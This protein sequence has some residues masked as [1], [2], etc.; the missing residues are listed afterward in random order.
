M[1]GI[2]CKDLSFLAFLSV[3][4]DGCRSCDLK[5]RRKRKD[6]IFET[7]LY[8]SLERGIFCRGLEMRKQGLKALWTICQGGGR[9]RKGEERERESKDRNGRRLREMC[10]GKGVMEAATNEKSLKERE[11]GLDF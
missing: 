7:Y 6:E 9:R 3:S 4:L 1:S 10:E 2:P 8:G 11:R 5:R